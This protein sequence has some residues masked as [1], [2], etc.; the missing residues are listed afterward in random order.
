MAVFAVFK[1]THERFVSATLVS[2]DGVKGGQYEA[3]YIC[4]G[5]KDSVPILNLGGIRGSEVALLRCLESLYA[6]N[7]LC[8]DP[9]C[10]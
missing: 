9:H 4:N 6:T 1:N 2:D 7:P 3:V 10:G 5:L 8:V